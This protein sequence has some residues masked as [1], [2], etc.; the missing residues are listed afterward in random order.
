MKLK[1]YRIAVAQLTQ[2]YEIMSPPQL[3][4]CEGRSLL[5]QSA[6]KLT[7]DHQLSTACTES[8]SYL[9]T[10]IKSKEDVW[11]LTGGNTRALK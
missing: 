3:A 11:G 2:E 9:V 7:E 5:L 1:N 6:S 10:A 8:N 4:H